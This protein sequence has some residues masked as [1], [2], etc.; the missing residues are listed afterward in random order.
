LT[1]KDQVRLGIGHGHGHG[2][3]KGFRSHREGVPCAV[4]LD[5]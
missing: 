3:G 2:D 5:A 1:V 4:P